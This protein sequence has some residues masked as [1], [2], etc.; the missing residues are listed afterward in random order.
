MTR[1]QHAGHLEIG[2]ITHVMEVIFAAHPGA[3]PGSTEKVSSYAN[4]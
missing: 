2:E 3:F 1:R 4:T